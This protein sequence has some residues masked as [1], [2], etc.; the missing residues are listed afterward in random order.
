VLSFNIEG[1]LPELYPP[2]G[3]PVP[4]I[5]LIKLFPKFAVPSFLSI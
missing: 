2:A 5:V 1:M 3:S 4:A